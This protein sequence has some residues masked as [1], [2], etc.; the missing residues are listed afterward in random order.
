MIGKRK[1]VPKAMLNVTLEPSVK[2]QP[3]VFIKTNEH[4]EASESD[5]ARKLLM[6]LRE[7]WQNAQDYAIH[8]AEQLVRQNY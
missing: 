1:D 3:G 2:V 4:Y 7:S 8:V 6:T 5:A